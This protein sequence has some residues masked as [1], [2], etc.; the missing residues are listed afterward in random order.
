[1]AI[2]L[3]KRFS[4]S[5][6]MHYP[7]SRLS[8]GERKQVMLLQYLTQARSLYLFDEPTNHLDEKEQKIFLQVVKQLKEQG[9]TI[10]YV[11]HYDRDLAIADNIFKI[12][13][14]QISRQE[15]RSQ[16]DTIL[17]QRKTDQS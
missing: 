14:K 2:A 10:I 15:Q 11:T 9:K 5:G 3:Q 13:H 12:E 16:L 8:S 17:L 4:V 1:Q 6:K 7:V